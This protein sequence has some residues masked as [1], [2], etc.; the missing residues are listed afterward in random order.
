MRMQQFQNS[1]EQE[2]EQMEKK[3]DLLKKE[4]VKDVK[5][6]DY[7]DEN[8]FIKADDSSGKFQYLNEIIDAV[9]N[10]NN[11][12]IKYIKDSER[13]SL[14]EDKL[15]SS[16]DLTS[17]MYNFYMLNSCITP[18][19][20]QNADLPALCNSVGMYIG[21]C[22]T[23]RDF[24][25]N[26]T[27]HIAEAATPYMEHVAKRFGKTEQFER[28]KQNMYTKRGM[29]VPLDPKNAAVLKV[30]MMNKAFDDIRDNPD[31]IEDINEKL[32]KALEM[33]EDN[34]MKDGI[35]PARLNRETNLL[36][37]HLA[38]VNPK[39]KHMFAEFSGD[40]KVYRYFEEVEVDGSK[41]NVWN[42]DL[43]LGDGK[44]LEKSLTLRNPKNLDDLNKFFD[45][46]LIP[47]INSCK[48][49]NELNKIMKSFISVDQSVHC[50]IP[51]GIDGMDKKFT[52][53]FVNLVEE[54]K[55]D[56]NTWDG[57]DDKL[58]DAFGECA[59]KIFEDCGNNNNF[60]RW[61]DSYGMAFMNK[62]ED[63]KVGLRLMDLDAFENEL[64]AVDTDDKI[65]PELF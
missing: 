57:S 21:I 58:R 25:K 41:F 45:E 32:N 28:Y 17:R 35:S 61:S 50:G 22:M 24:H 12:Y 4:S 64:T 13:F 33:L 14:E 49:P 19:M 10:A 56:F 47:K 7:F 48:T 44:L 23:N 6:T 38:E 39:Y 3:K 11:D 52:G 60:K 34:A 30:A 1:F 46:K 16:M 2:K 20:K 8:K 51:I 63:S 37:G 43:Y 40:N 55:L 15:G 18:L 26:I 54:L 9:A 27:M 59:L 5:E 65:G 62:F 31:D 36:I 42:G 29:R 53:E